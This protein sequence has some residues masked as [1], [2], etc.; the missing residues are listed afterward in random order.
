MMAHDPDMYLVRTDDSDGWHWEGRRAR[1]QLGSWAV[2]M[3]CAPAGHTRTVEKKQ[4]PAVVVH[5]AEL[6]ELVAIAA[7][8]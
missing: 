7:T 1:R 8:Q 4:R 2:G 5:L 6:V 3:L